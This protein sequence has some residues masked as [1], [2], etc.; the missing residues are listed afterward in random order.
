MRQGDGDQEMEGDARAGR[1]YNNHQAFGENG[2]EDDDD[3]DE[4]YE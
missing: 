4:M 2:S 1:Y 3:S